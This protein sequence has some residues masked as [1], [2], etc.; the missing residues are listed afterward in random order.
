MWKLSGGEIIG[1]GR[2]PADYIDIEQAKAAFQGIHARYVLVI[3]DEAAGIPQWLW[4]AV[5]SLI[6]NEN[7]RILAIGNP[8][9]PTSQFA[10]VCSPGSGWN[11]IRIDY[12][13][14]PNFTDE[15][16]PEYLN[17]LLTSHTWVEE[18]RKR[19]GEGSPLWESRVR[20]RFPQR[21]TD[22]LIQPSWISQ[23][24]ERSLPPAIDDH[25]QY[26][27]DVARSGLDASVITHRRGNRYRIVFSETGLGDTM[28]LVGHVHTHVLK[29][30]P[31]IAATTPIFVDLIGIGAGVYDRLAE[32]G[33]NVGGF[34]S[35]HKAY[36]S[37]RFLNR[38]A[39]QYWLLREKFRSGQMDIDPEDEELATQ[40]VSIKWKVN[41]AGKIQVESKEEMKKRGIAS[42]DR[43]DSLM[44]SSVE[45]V[46]W[47]EDSSSS[48]IASSGNE[49][50]TGDL[51]V[52][53]W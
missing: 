27:V 30:G 4:D 25:G 17:D 21:S 39:E 26:G 49:S 46:V 33:F 50:L 6:T 8:D 45:D 15:K 18:R 38:R 10:K 43:A 1:F 37:K 16:V 42:P 47:P 23:A 7:A 28:R 40:L 9:D 34:N 20:G 3:I 41:S 24:Q 14:T 44:M 29:P 2:K 19:W 5:E 22:V 13:D 51:M 36:D 53:E 11:V 32:Q 12:L 48:N 52:T 35:S 31:A